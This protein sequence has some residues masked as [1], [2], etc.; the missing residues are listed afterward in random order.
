MPFKAAK[1]QILDLDRYFVIPADRDIRLL[2]HRDRRSIS[3]EILCQCGTLEKAEQVARAMN[4]AEDRG[5][6]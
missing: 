2:V 5:L 3:D 6:L 1:A 4:A